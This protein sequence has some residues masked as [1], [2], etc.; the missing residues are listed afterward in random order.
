MGILVL[1][2]INRIMGWLLLRMRVAG[3]HHLLLMGMMRDEI[4]GI[5]E[6]RKSCGDGQQEP[7]E[8]SLSS[9]QRMEFV[10]SRPI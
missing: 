5:W 9:R 7:D 3:G 6:S 10:V 2:W 4:S 8:L 1:G